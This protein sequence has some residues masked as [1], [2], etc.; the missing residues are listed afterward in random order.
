MKP[1]LSEGTGY[2]TVYIEPEQI[3][4][5]VDIRVLYFELLENGSEKPTG[6]MC[7]LRYVPQ[8]II[9]ISESLVC[10]KEDPTN[11]R[12][13]LNHVGLAH[14]RKEGSIKT[15]TTSKYGAIINKIVKK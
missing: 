2:I 8:G 5:L 11:Y 15:V 6:K 12:L 7:Q 9:G 13:I 3:Q 14:L 4:R 10:L 1:L